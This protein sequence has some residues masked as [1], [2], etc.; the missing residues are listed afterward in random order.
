MSSIQQIALR[1]SPLRPINTSRWLQRRW[2]RV[3][4][5]RFVT[6]QASA[7]IIDRYKE[8]LDEKVRKEGLKDVNQLKEVYKDKI[9]HLRNQASPAA[10]APRKSVQQHQPQPS[11]SDSP[12]PTPPAPPQ[13]QAAQKQSSSSKPYKTLSSYIDIEKT[14]SLPHKEIEAIWRLRHAENTQSL[15]AA[16]PTN[17]W[18]SI[19][20]TARRHPQ[21]ILPGLPRK[22]IEGEAAAD[23][24]VPEGAPIHFLQWTFP[25]PDTVTVLFT[26]LAEYKIRGEHAQPHT[27]LTHHLELSQ[28][29]GLVL[30]Q[31][32][33]VPGRGV[34]IEEGKWLILC[35][36]K[37]Y[38]TQSIQEIES[39]SNDTE[40]GKDL[41]KA[42][43]KLIEQFNAGDTSFNIEELLDQAERMG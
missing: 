23:S 10:N 38:N 11:S 39:T 12:W 9:Q 40:V 1:H 8:K 21:F 35:M 6:Q 3:H 13:P 20:S 2:A 31:G 25:G 29:N 36:Q 14:R 22:A 7:R 34:S 5:V 32:A 28:S 19:H 42:R 33:V 4:D 30:S 43:R 16:I 27:I 37:F 26:H 15:C 41:R 18:S 17:V 24:P